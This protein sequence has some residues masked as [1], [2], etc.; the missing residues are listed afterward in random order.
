MRPCGKGTRS[1]GAEDVVAMLCV[2]T[3]MRQNGGHIHSADIHIGG[4]IVVIV[5]KQENADIKPCWEREGW[6]LFEG[7]MNP[8]REQ[9]LITFTK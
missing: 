2:S 8:Q 3:L 6:H 9:Y 7:E 4:K 5:R 1:G